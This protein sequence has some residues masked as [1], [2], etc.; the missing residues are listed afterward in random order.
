MKDK[1]GLYS[2]ERADDF[3]SDEVF[4]KVSLN[5]DNP[6]FSGHFPGQPVLPGVM[7]LRLFTLCAGDALGMALELKET[8]QCKFLNVVDPGRFTNLTVQMKIRQDAHFITVMAELKGEDINFSKA[9]L[10]LIRK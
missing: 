5:P 10:K 3:S 7:I 2:F 9:N 4:Y 8:T 6:I 1:L